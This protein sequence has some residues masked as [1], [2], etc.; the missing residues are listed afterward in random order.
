MMGMK[1]WRRRPSARPTRGAEFVMAEA[2]ISWQPLGAAS[3]DPLWPC[4]LLPGGTRG[5]P[6][7]PNPAKRGKNGREALRDPLRLQWA[8]GPLAIQR[9][10][11]RSS[12]TR[13]DSRCVRSRTAAHYFPMCTNF[14][15]EGNAV[16]DG[17][18]VASAGSSQCL[19]WII[20][21]ASQQLD[22]RGGEFA[23][24]CPSQRT[25]PSSLDNVVRCEPMSC[26]TL[27]SNFP[28]GVNS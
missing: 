22:S 25:A 24:V 10:S 3:A 11:D 17:Y 21:V 13:C 5:P 15:P 26:Q 18:R 19:S 1:R 27:T 12:K 8:G 14:L 28:Q 7:G 2:A 4:S 6:A 20:R 9:R 16:G 23:D